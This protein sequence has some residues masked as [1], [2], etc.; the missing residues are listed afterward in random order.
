MANHAQER[1]TQFSVTATNATSS[2]ASKAGVASTTYY[3]TDIAGSSDK[4]ASQLLV[5]DGT[6]VIWQMQLLQT[7]AGVSSYSHSFATPLRC[8]SG[9]LAS[10]TVDSTAYGTANISGYAL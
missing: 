2:V 6:T 9:N 8:T 1:G 10:V 4:A 3:I 5:K 7:A